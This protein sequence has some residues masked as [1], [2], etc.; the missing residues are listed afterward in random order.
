MILDVLAQSE[1]P[2]AFSHRVHFADEG[3]D[4]VDCHSAWEDSDDPG[5]PLAGQCALCHAELDAASPPERRVA[6]LFE[7]DRFAARHAGALPDEVSFSHRQHATRGDECLACHAAIAENDGLTS[8]PAP[9][10][11]VDMDDCL[12]CHAADSG[13]PEADCA[14]C[15]AKIR[16]DQAPP[17]HGANWKDFHGTVVRART[18]L[19]ADRCS[20]CHEESSCA[21]CHHS[22]LPVSHNNHWRRRGHGLVASM[23]RNRC[24]TC[25]D[26]DSCNRCHQETRPLDHVGLWGAPK[27]LHC[28]TC[29]EPLRSEACSVCHATA[30]SHDLATPL[31]PDHLPG[32]DCR[33]C[34]GNGQPLP[35]VDNGQICTSCHR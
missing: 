5:L 15:H 1:R 10:L 16:G 21:S 26:S 2:F 11:L 25:H 31:P 13:P 7:G 33:A 27:D 24:V 20:L 3:L 28:L 4:C 23:D 22:E 9:E 32:M 8:E 34:H 30:A 6:T 17:S 35:H 29:H 19:R 12:A 18:D 14:A